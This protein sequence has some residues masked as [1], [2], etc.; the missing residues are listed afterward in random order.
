MGKT[1][2]TM[3]ENTGGKLNV[4]PAY[5]EIYRLLGSV[6]HHTDADKIN[7]VRTYS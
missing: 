7:M 1:S 4:H 3:I 2:D 6:V 5:S